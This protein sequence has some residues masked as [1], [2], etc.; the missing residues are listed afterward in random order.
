MFQFRTKKL[1]KSFHSKKFFLIKETKI[2]KKNVS[3]NNLKKLVIFFIQ[4]LKTKTI[5]GFI[6]SSKAEEQ[7]KTNFAIKKKEKRSEKEAQRE[8]D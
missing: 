6:Y 4:K 2:K 8:F 7:P 1:D 3:K 5:K